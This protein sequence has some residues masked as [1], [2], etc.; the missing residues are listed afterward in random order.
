MQICDDIIH[1]FIYCQ[2]KAYLKHRQQTGIISDYQTLY[3]HLKQNQKSC[4]E[5]TLLENKI[6]TYSN[7]IFD[8]KISNEGISLNIKFTNADIDLILDGIEFASNKNVIP[9]FI[10]PFENITKY[11]KLFITIQSYLIQDEFNIHIDSCKIIYGKHLKQ[12]RYKLLL[13][14][15]SIKKTVN[16]MDK[17]ISDSVTPSLVLNKHC[18]ICEYYSYCIEKA[19]SDDNLSL[20]DRGNKQNN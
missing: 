13:S 4:V 5:K 3:N 16:D 1:S 17:I 12:T 19:K 6:L 11:D 14:A 9:I 18:I 8:N 20:L 10:T 7:S 2:Y 15:K